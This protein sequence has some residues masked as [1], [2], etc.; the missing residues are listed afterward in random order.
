MSLLLLFK[1]VLQNVINNVQALLLVQ[2]NQL[3]FLTKT[4]LANNPLVA[5][6]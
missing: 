1:Y 2:H 4:Q 3:S 5:I 6:V